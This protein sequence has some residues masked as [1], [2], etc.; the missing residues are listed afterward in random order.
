MINQPATFIKEYLTH[1]YNSQSV[2]LAYGVIITWTHLTHA[3]SIYTRPPDQIEVWPGGDASR[4]CT[5]PHRNFHPILNTLT[6]NFHPK[7][8]TLASPSQPCNSHSHLV[9]TTLSFL[10]LILI[11]YSSDSPILITVLGNFFTRKAWFTLRFSYGKQ[12][13]FI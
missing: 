6:Y 12:G 5:V 3:Q 9:T 11:V 1:G 4:L 13:L 10:I 8:Y 2:I 7:P